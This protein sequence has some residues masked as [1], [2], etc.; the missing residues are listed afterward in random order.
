MSSIINHLSSFSLRRG[1]DNAEM[2]GSIIL[3]NK[4]N[5]YKP[6]WSGD[7]TM[8]SQVKI[9][10]G[11]GSAGDPAKAVAIAGLVTQVNNV[12]TAKES[13]DQISVRLISPF[14]NYLKNKISTDWYENETV[15]TICNSI[16]SAF[17]DWALYDFSACAGTTIAKIRFENES[18]PVILRKLCEAAGCDLF[19]K[20][21]GT[22][23]ARAFPNFDGAADWTYAKGEISEFTSADQ[24]DISVVN[25]MNLKGK[26]FSPDE[27]R[28]IQCFNDT[29]R[30]YNKVSPYEYYNPYLI[31]DIIFDKGPVWGARFETSVVGY[32]ETISFESLEVRE[33]GMKILCTR[34]GGV[35]YSDIYFTVECYGRPYRDSEANQLQLTSKN[36]TLLKLY[37][38]LPMEQNYENKVIQTADALRTVGE[39]KLKQNLYKLNRKT[40]KTAHNPSL[41]LND[42]VT[43]TLP[44]DST[45]KLLVRAIRCSGNM[46]KS[47]LIDVLET[48]VIAATKSVQTYTTDA[49]GNLI[50]DTIV[51]EEV[52]A[53]IGE[54]DSVLPNTNRIYVTDNASAYVET[55][56]PGE[57]VYIIGS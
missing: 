2:S 44:D 55:E 23:F 39:Y 6:D 1:V 32:P 42:I 36:Y 8:D 50:A 19:F 7:I 38:N 3:S 54:I 27:I 16:V 35:P 52:P 49:G 24:M 56:T 30:W 51:D 57:L 45:L 33:D 28:E 22:I 9:Q 31:L 26:M 40:Y 5:L 15:Q 10:A 47:E 29:F 17:M 37:N 13:A 12:E 11:Y 46:N 25:T 21:D 34:A 4:S 41:E 18:P 20:A 48:W 14:K 53:G 43:G